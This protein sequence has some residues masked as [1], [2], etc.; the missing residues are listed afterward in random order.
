MEDNYPMHFRFEGNLY[1]TNKTAS[2]L[3]MH[4]AY[5]PPHYPE[6]PIKLPDGRFLRVTCWLECY[7]PKAGEIEITENCD[8]CKY[9]IAKFPPDDY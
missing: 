7:P 1:R 8:A 9:A 5:Y 2:E 3:Y 4:L 6:I